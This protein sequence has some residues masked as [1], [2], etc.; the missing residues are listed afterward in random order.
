MLPQLNTLPNHNYELKIFCP[1]DLSIKKMHVLMIVYCTKISLLNWRYV[2]H[3]GYH[4][5]KR[6]LMKVSGEKEIYGSPSEI[7]WYLSIIHRFKRLF[8]IKNYAKN[9]TWHANGR[10]CDNL[11]YSKIWLQMVWIFIRT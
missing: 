10:N 11:K 3:V 7:L 2:Q 9:L 6:N 4:S 5:L 8:V 1:I